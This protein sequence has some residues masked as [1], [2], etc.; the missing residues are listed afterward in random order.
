MAKGDFRRH[1]VV[2]LGAGFAGLA[3]AKD[4]SRADEVS[5]VVIDR[6]PTHTYH[7]YLYEVATGL[8]HG[9]DLVGAAAL[10]RGVS[11]DYEYLLRGWHVGFAHNGVSAVDF[12]RKVVTT[13]DDETYPFD[14][15]IVAFGFDTDFFDIPGLADR[16]MRMNTLPDALA[17]R[18]R[19][20]NFVAKKRLG[21]EV[22][23]RVL[24]GGGGATG[25]ETAAE[26]AHFFQHRQRMG[27]LHSGDWNVRLVEASPRLLSMLPP[28]L[29]GHALR[30]L[31]KLGVKVML[32]T[33]IKRVEDHHVILAPRPLK[34]G[35][36]TDGLLCEF[37]AEAERAFEADVLVWCGGVRGSAS[38]KLLGLPLDRKDRLAV[39]QTL[40]VPGTNGV[41]AVGD[42]ASLVNPVDGKPVPG[43][44]QSAIEMGH[45]AATNILRTLRNQ[46]LFPF[47]FHPYPTVIPLGGKN[48]L[49][50]LGY[51]HPRGVLGWS[52]RQ[53]ATVLYYVTILP[54][55]NSVFTFIRAVFSYTR[56]D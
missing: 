10:T 23:L 27:E 44:A 3:A 34:P 22:A 48:A 2:I 53:A 52:V 36:T 14:T 8:M 11:F 39:D 49:A 28:H 24:I 19:L 45:V 26:L 46:K 47:P 29:S 37:R 51:I 16:S 12:S 38:T 50:H 54:F 6:S 1:R 43:L 41:Y 56:N 42:C 21:K 7:P 20:M 55:F 13:D 33:C 32:D 31:E 25:V 9:R 15:L 30:R 40:R 18:E 35:E 4:L 5:V 17:L